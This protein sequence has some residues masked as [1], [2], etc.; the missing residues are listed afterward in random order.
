MRVRYPVLVE[1]FCDR[2][3]QAM[4][5]VGMPQQDLAEQLGGF[6]QET[7]SRLSRNSATSLPI[8]LLVRICEWADTNGISIRWMILGVGT[9]MKSDISKLADVAEDINQ[10]TT[11]RLILALAERSGIDLSDVVDDLLVAVHVPDHGFVTKPLIEAL[12]PKNKKAKRRR[13]H[14]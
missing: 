10:M 5:K 1:G 3:R 8:D 9:M 2:F 4:A 11:N 14:K 6:R 7:I 12:G 13:K